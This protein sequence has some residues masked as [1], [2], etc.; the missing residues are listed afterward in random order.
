LF[1]FAKE[2]ELHDFKKRK[3]NNEKKWFDL[4]AKKLDVDFDYD[5]FYN[6]NNN[7]EENKKFLN[8]KRKL[9]NKEKFKKKR[10][11]LKLRENN[12]KSS[13]FLTPDQVKKLNDLMK[14]DEFKNQNLTQ[15]LNEAKYDQK[16]IKK[17][18]KPKQKRYMHR[19][20][21]K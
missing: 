9:I 6:N 7:D 18:Y 11:Y 20:K 14:D 1:E 8:K 3:E 17:K 15:S 16:F 2:V 10:I 12:I 19:R 5:L 13:S 4:N 21:G